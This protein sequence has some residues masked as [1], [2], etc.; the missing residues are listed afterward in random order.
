[1]QLPFIHSVEG[2]DHH[3][4]Q[5]GARFQIER[6]VAPTETPAPFGHRFLRGFVEIVR[7]M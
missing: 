3:Q 1:M 7:F 6:I 2:R 5:H 4:I